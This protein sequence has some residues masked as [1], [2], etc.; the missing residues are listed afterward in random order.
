MKIFVER[1]NPHVYSEGFMQ[2][3]INLANLDEH[4]R[5]QLVFDPKSADCILFI[6]AHYNLHVD[7]LSIVSEHTLTKKYPYKIFLYNEYDRPHL[8]C[9]GLVVSMPK[10]LFSRARHRAV[11]YATNPM[12]Q[13]SS[14]V[15]TTFRSKFCFFA[16]GCRYNPTR[17]RIVKHLS[18]STVDIAD[19]SDVSPWVTGAHAPSETQRTKSM[20]D[21]RRKLI[22]YQYCLCPRGMGASSFRLFEALAMG[23]VPVVLSDDFVQP[24]I[25]DW[26]EGV[27]A[28]PQSRPKSILSDQEKLFGQYQ[29]RQQSISRMYRAHFSQSSRWNYFGS[30]LESLMANNGPWRKPTKSDDLI[31]RAYW[32]ICRALKRLEGYAVKWT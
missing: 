4:D 7:Y 25:V 10:V 30:E 6:D 32:L 16:G 12:D 8:A 2:Q 27:V 1:A 23:S 5:H 18:N 22:E 29:C 11:C 17:Q 20:N 31:N 13:Y 19:T 28:Y 9:R 3:F 21:Y 14:E 24:D 26:S 15:L